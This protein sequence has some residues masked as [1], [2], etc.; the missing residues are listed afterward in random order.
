MADHHGVFA[1]DGRI[2]VARSAGDA[3]RFRYEGW[4]EQATDNSGEI[5][6]G[7]DLDAALEAADLP[8]TGTAE[9][10]RARLAEQQD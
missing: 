4:Q 5:L 2:R 7:A 9:E 10:K 3:V 6:R 1:K 8:K